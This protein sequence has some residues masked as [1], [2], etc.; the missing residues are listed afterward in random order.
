MADLLVLGQAADV[1]ASPSDRQP[2]A[3][4]TA[5]G[6]YVGSKVCANCHRQ[7]YEKYSQTDMGRSL[8]AVTPSLFEKIPKSAQVFDQRSNRY[9]ELFDKDG[10]FF[11]TEYETAPDGRE[12]FRETHKME[13]II[14][15][16]ANGFGSIVRRGDSLFEAP[17]SFYTKPGA[18]ALSPGYELNDYGFSRPILPPCISCHSGRPEPIL[19]GNGRFREP[20]FSERAIGCENCHGPGLLHLVEQQQDEQVPANGDS[21]I[22]NPARLPSWLADNICISCHQT[23]DASVL[24][25]GK[26][27][28]DFRPGTPLDET[29]AIF[30]VP[31]DR[32]TPTQSD[33]LQHYLSM[34]LSKCYRSSGRRLGCITC[35]DPH[36][37][38]TEQAAPSYYRAKCLTCHTE[39][40]CAVPLAVRQKKDPPD[41]CAGCHM[42][43]RDVK[44][45]SHAVLTNH[46]IVAIAEEA[47]PEIAFHLTTPQL[48][49]L[50]HLTAIPGEPAKAP[51]S[52]TLLQAYGQLMGSHPDFR[53]RYFSLAKQLEAQYSDNVEIL[54]ARAA[55]ELEQRNTEGAAAAIRYLSHAVER[56][57]TSPADFEQLAVLLVRT[58]RVQEANGILQEGIQRI[59]Y[60]AELYLLL[61]ENYLA[62]NQP[63]DALGTCAAR[64]ESRVTQNR[65]PRNRCQ[66]RSHVPHSSKHRQERKLRRKSLW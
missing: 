19:Q 61:A 22:V 18:W 39:K 7:I 58:G 15:S 4:G 64:G 45:I 21:T 44:V 26:T 60:D 47:L 53:E 59:P 65:A 56:G 8:A 66:G 32:A 16:G 20:P 13:W 28:Q 63:A 23:G 37:Q 2:N 9:F 1:H 54:E 36:V 30:T 14:G 43:K 46:R 6:S 57:A 42:P 25:P 55:A 40:S 29:L 51:A 33:L 35:H 41:N 48:P 38:P 24:Q 12:L 50:V 10:D 34:T 31:F 3:P 52:L 5:A 11:Q 62:L 17:L 49:D 27:F